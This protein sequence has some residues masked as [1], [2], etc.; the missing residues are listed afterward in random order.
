M[1][2]TNSLVGQ[3]RR[4]VMLLARSGSWKV[5]LYL[6]LFALFVFLVIYFLIK[7]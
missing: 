6:F 1:E 7:R 2:N 4:R 5:Y 3:A